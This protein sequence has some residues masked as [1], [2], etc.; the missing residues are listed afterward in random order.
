MSNYSQDFV[1]IVK[2]HERTPASEDT[3]AKK[4]FLNSAHY[5]KVGQKLWVDRQFSVAVL[6]AI[7]YN[8]LQSITIAL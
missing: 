4:L 3:E 8:Q 2:D 7:F 6:N 1:V 5:F